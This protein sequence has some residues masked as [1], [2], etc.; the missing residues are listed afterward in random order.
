ME[1]QSRTA[2]FVLEPRSC[3]MAA[4]GRRWRH[5]RNAKSASTCYACSFDGRRSP[6]LLSFAVRPPDLAYIAQ[7]CLKARPCKIA[8]TS[9]RSVS[10]LVRRLVVLWVPP[11]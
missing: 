5:S 3:N 10:T 8:W 9:A 6:V 2:L 4:T 1:P 11:G 7:A